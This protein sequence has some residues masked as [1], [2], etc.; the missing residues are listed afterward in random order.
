MAAGADNRWSCIYIYICAYIVR[1][2]TRQWLRTNETFTIRIRFWKTRRVFVR[3]RCTIPRGPFVFITR[4]FI[5]VARARRFFI[6]GKRLPGK[7][8]AFSLSGLI[9]RAAAAA[10]VTGDIV[11][12]GTGKESGRTAA[13]PADTSEGMTGDG[14]RRWPVVGRAGCLFL[15]LSCLSCLICSPG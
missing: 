6:H 15:S 1:V 13:E 11:T 3:A 10:A 9:F 2:S 8:N 14:R 7:I 12:Y 4:V 5:N